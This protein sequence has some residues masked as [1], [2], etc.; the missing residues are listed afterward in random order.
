M[1]QANITPLMQIGEHNCFICRKTFSST[2]NLN[3]HMDFLHGN[4]QR[5]ECSSR[6]CHATFTRRGDLHRHLDNTCNQAKPTST[7][8]ADVLI[9][10]PPSSHSNSEDSS[11]ASSRHSSRASREGSRPSQSRS[12]RESDTSSTKSRHR[13]RSHHSS[14]S[15]RASKRSRRRDSSTSGSSAHHN[16]DP[17]PSHQMSPPTQPATP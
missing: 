14:R 1:T 13:E 10:H 2:S 15:R 11:R 5:I 3:R 16:R 8:P 17:T 6:G 4:Q 9:L 12:A 7:P